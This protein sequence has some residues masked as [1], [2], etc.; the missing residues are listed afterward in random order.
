MAHRRDGGHSYVGQRAAHR[1]GIEGC[2]IFTRAAAPAHDAEINPAQ[3]V[4]QPQ[5]THELFHSSF[6]LNPGAE[7][8]QVDAG[9]ALAGDRDYVVDR[10]AITAGHQ[11]Y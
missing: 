10:R 4:H 7:H 3:P 6:T 11:G 2:E 1:F 9:P 5:G 8:E